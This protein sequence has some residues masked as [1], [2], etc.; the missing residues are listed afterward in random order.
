MIYSHQGKGF[1]LFRKVLS[2]ACEYNSALIT[3][4]DFGI[5]IMFYFIFN[6][7]IIYYT[8]H[9][10]K[11]SKQINKLKII[12]FRSSFFLVLY[13]LRNLLPLSVNFGDCMVWMAVLSV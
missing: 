6:V 3:K 12:I 5:L 9:I 11:Q 13:H 8:I 1:D 7:L 4:I 10:L 2:R